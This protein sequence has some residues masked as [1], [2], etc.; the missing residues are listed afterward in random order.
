M[1]IYLGAQQL[2]SIN[3]GTDVISQI[4]LGNDLIYSNGVVPEDTAIIK[5][6]YY[7]LDEN[8]KT[9]T[10]RNVYFSS[11]YNDFGNYDIAIPNVFYINGEKY[12]TIVVFE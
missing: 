12:S 6:F 7:T 9:I 11:W 5:Y 10:I 4:Y 8:E 3:F 1:A 2:T